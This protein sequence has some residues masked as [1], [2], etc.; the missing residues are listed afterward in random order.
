MTSIKLDEK[1]F[2]SFLNELSQINIT[3][4]NYAGNTIHELIRFKKD[5]E[6]LVV[7]KSRTI[8]LENSQ[9]FQALID[10]VVDTNLDEIF[11]NYD[12]II[13][14]DEVGKGEWY[15]PLITAAVCLTKQQISK[16][17]LLGV[18]DSKSLN[19]NQIFQ[20]FDKARQINYRRKTVITKP[21]S[22]N[23]LWEDFTKEGKNYNDLIAWQHQR[24]ILDI[25]KGIEI[26][27]RILIIIDKFDINKVDERLKNLSENEFI[28]IKQ[29]PKGESYVP[30]AFAS[31]IAKKIWYQEIEVL[32]RKYGLDFPRVKIN[33]IDPL[34]VNKTGKLF[35]KNVRLIVNS[36][37]LSKNLEYLLSTEVQSF[38]YFDESIQN[39]ILEIFKADNTIYKYLNLAYEF[40][41]LKNQ[42]E[43]ANAQRFIEVIEN[44]RILRIK[45]DFLE[46][47]DPDFRIKRFLV[48]QLKQKIDEL[49]NIEF[50]YCLK[51][52][53]EI[54]KTISAFCNRYILTKTESY[55]V[56][57]IRDLKDIPE[58]FKIEERIID[59]D[60]MLEISKLKTAS[61]FQFT[62]N[63]L[64][65]SHLDP[66]PDSCYVVK[67]IN[68]KGYANIENDLEVIIIIIRDFNLER[69]IQFNKE[70]YLR[71][72]GQ[73]VKASHSDIEQLLT[74]ILIK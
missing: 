56:F 26:K 34:I 13:G 32:N 36:Q 57:G 5:T 61:D 25:L 38:N 53:D 44:E 30:V 6:L 51:N 2:K 49:D 46:K 39:E 42:N 52:K 63:R 22:L 10:K 4:E 67:S 50:K 18:R 19:R 15:G 11:E 41:K 69:P 33:D 45:I 40:K 28:D 23:K 68:L 29:I 24:A 17:Q 55:I 14:S 54:A 35:F 43:I 73:D 1:Q 9:R 12:L 47:S 48:H 66:C 71:K 64:T 58:I 20:L 16:L 37:I 72:G 65:K 7:Y 31:I 70:F 3:V 27:K 59:L 74:K 62:V 60:T 8:L 21:G